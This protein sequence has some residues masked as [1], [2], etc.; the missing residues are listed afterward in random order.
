MNTEKLKKKLRGMLFSGEINMNCEA[1]QNS[2]EVTFISLVW[3][4]TSVLFI[5]K[6]YH[7]LKMVLP[8][9]YYYRNVFCCTPGALPTS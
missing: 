1:G 6:V 2:M 4:S 7:M 5:C 3:C 9:L 8:Y